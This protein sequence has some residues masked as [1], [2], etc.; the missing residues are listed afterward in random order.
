MVGD[1]LEALG[2]YLAPFF[3]EKKLIFSIDF[4]FNKKLIFFKRFFGQN[5][6]EKKNLIF[7]DFFPKKTRFCQGGL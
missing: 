3:F 7:P 6:V 4:F 5:S 1:F 2:Y